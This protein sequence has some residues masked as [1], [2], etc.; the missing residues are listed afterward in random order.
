MTT[1]PLQHK[2][3]DHSCLFLQKPHPSL[4]QTPLQENMPPQR[5]S[6]PPSRSLSPY[7]HPPSRNEENPRP[8]I[9]V[10]GFDDLI[11]LPED[12]EAV[13]IMLFRRQDL[14]LKTMMY[15]HIHETRK[16]L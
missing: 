9:D 4:L 1:P 7:S 15:K 16:R 11:D 14:L 2:N 13:Q 10:Y 6:P 12:Y 3:K 8:L 5:Q